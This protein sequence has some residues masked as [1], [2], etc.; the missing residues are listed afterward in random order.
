MRLCDAAAKD[1]HV[2][3]CYFGEGATSEGDFHAGLNFA[4][5]RKAPVIFF[6][7]N[8]QYAI[9]TPVSRQFSSAGVAPKA[10]GYG[11]EA[12]RVDGNDFFAVYDGVKKARAYC[13]EGKGP[14]LIEAMT[15]R[16]GAHSTADDP[17]VYR[18]DAEVQEWE[19]N[20]PFCALRTI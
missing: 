9:S 7:R 8:N 3:I 2:V 4:A 6:C 10:E 14:F 20:V 17:S 16:L 11:I 5:V 15:Y 13:L 19:K 1:P 12:L 18:K